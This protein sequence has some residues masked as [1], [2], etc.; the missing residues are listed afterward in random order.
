RWDEIDHPS[1][2]QWIFPAMVIVAT[3]VLWAMRKKI[4]RGVLVAWL[5]FCGTLVPALSFVN[6]YPMRYSFVADH[7]QYHASIA[8]IVLF[9]AVIAQMPPRRHSTSSVQVRGAIW[10]TIVV[11]LGGLTFYQTRIYKD[12]QTLWRDTQVKNPN[13]WMVY[14][15]LGNVLATQG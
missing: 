11:V 4:G 3:V 15:N 6:V 9:A 1:A 13:S 5:L 8:M 2:V 14:T 7:F 10:G 12:A